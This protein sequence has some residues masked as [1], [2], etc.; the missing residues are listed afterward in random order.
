[1]SIPLRFWSVLWGCE[2]LSF[3]G[4]TGVFMNITLMYSALDSECLQ[5]FFSPSAYYYDHWNCIKFSRTAEGS[6]WSPYLQELSSRLLC[7]IKYVHDI[8]NE[9]YHN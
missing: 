9:Y 7:N 3:N 1:M 5:K 2:I 6:L 4:D 8:P